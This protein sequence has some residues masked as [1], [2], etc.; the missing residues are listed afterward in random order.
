MKF[1]FLF[2]DGVG[3]GENNNA[4]P[5]TTADVE[6][7]KLWK[8][9]ILKT[10]HLS[11]KA[12]DPLMGIN[13][14]PQSA[15]GQTTIFT[16][17]NAPKLLSN[18]IG[19]FPNRQ[20][21]KVIKKEN[22]FL[23]LKKLGKKGKFINAYPQHSELFSNKHINIDDNG[24]FAFSNDFPEKYK[25][26][27]SVTSS[28]LISNNEK[29]FDTE[30]ICQQKSLYQ[31]YTNISLQKYKL[32]IPVFSPVNAASIIYNTSAN[33]DLILYEF[34]Q[35]D[36][37]GHRKNFDEKVKLISDLDNLISSLISISDHK[38]DTIFITSDHGNLED[39]SGKSHTY[40]PV[41][42]IIWG[43]GHRELSNKIKNLS[44]ITPNILNFIDS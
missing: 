37:Y 25:R 24:N 30:E 41:P 15:T 21:R 14:I 11:F 44:D 20:L 38:T 6:I 40:N 33:Y 22:I 27:I 17:I 19:S 29:P 8:N 34:F 9:S 23:K 36:I 26:R 5:F 4:N 16:G 35:T 18:H 10:P 13:G 1:I 32:D 3:I 43:K 2:L 42:L 12:I 39:S 28:I 7:L 31:D